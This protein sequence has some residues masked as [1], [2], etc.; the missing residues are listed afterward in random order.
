[1]LETFSKYH[2]VQQPLELEHVDRAQVAPVLVSQEAE[3]GAIVNHAQDVA[4]VP[5]KPGARI[6]IFITRI[7]KKYI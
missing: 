4:N 7:P 5:Y 2:H 1:M 3:E 6:F